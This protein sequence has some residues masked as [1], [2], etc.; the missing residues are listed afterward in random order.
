[1]EGQSPTDIYERIMVVYGDDAP[2]RTTVFEWARRFK[3]GQFTIEDGPRSGRPSTA[4]DDQTIEAVE[5][6]VIED[7]RITIQQISDIL[8]SSTGTVH[9][10]LH[11]QLRMTKFCSTWVPHLLTLDQRHQRVEACEE[12][13]ARYSM[14]GNDFLFRI[15]TGDESFFY[16]YQPES[17]QTSKQ[18]KRADS[19]PPTKLKQEKST[20]KVFYS[21][22]WDYKG[23]IV[24][25]PAP[26]GTTITKTYYENILVNELHPEIK[27]Q[28]RGLLS[29]GVILHHGNA[30]AHTSHLVSSAIHNL[31]YEVLRH[32]P[33]SSDLM[34]SDYFLFRVLKDYLRGRHYN[35]RS[36]LGSSI[37]QCLN[38]VSKDDFTTAIQ[39]LP[40]RWQRCI[41]A[42][43]RYFE[44]E[45]MY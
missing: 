16:F 2:S 12:L 15:V 36:S 23:I 3:D 32:P 22:F 6:L 17:K 10:I 8:R 40:E 4:T 24:K 1:M 42:E 41:S 26:V 25:E 14:E 30:P 33:Y 31:Q 37:H 21:F 34:P 20:N 38:S 27:K 5:S 7:R 19:P 43:G 28:R 45:H 39:K 18:W 29:A 35:D 9:N 13:L 11:E 44:K